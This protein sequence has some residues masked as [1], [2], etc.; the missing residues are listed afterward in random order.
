MSFGLILDSKKSDKD[1]TVSS[2]Y[3]LHLVSHDVNIMRNHGAF[4]KTKTLT[5]VRYYELKCRLDS[6]FTS[7]SPYVLFIKIIIIIIK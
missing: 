7:F 1:S 5:S 4:V 2:H 6:D 3:T